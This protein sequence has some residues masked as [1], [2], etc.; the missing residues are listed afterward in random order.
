LL[1]KCQDLVREVGNLWARKSLTS[2]KV[3]SDLVEVS[4]SMLRVTSHREKSPLIK[5]RES[6]IQ[7][8][9]IVQNQSLPDIYNSNNLIAMSKVESKKSEQLSMDNSGYHPDDL[10][11][12][13]INDIL[14]EAKSQS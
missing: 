13:I 2:D 10:Q 14:A 5:E 6:A 11:P 1:A 7:K 3:F 4:N 12:K 9:K 8:I